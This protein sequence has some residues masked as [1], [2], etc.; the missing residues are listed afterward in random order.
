[1]EHGQLMNY[2]IQDMIHLMEVGQQVLDTGMELRL[3][4]RQANN[5]GG[6]DKLTSKEMGMR[7]WKVDWKTRH[8]AL[9]MHQSRMVFS[10][11]IS[12]TMVSV[13]MSVQWSTSQAERLISPDMNPISIGLQ[14]P[15]FGLD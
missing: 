3:H 8:V 12:T 1:M 5:G 10:L 14:P 15:A 6:L 2:Q 11:N 9:V 13:T 4:S 7:P